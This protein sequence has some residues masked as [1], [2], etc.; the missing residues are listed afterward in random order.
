[1]G[2]CTQMRDA[3]RG[4][5]DGAGSCRSLRK[6]QLRKESYGQVNNVNL[7]CEVL[8]H[9]RCLKELVLSRFIQRDEDWSKLCNVVCSTHSLESLSIEGVDLGASCC[10]PGNGFGKNLRD[11]VT[12]SRFAKTRVRARGYMSSVADIEEIF[13][14]NKSLRDLDL[15]LFRMN[16]AQAR[17]VFSGLQANTFLEGMTLRGLSLEAPTKDSLLGC[18]RNGSIKRLSIFGDLDILTANQ[19]S[20]LI[21]ANQTKLEDFR[22]RESELND[23]FFLNLRGSMQLKRLE[24]YGKLPTEGSSGCGCLKLVS[25]HLPHLE[26]VESLLCANLEVRCIESSVAEIA[27]AMEQNW[28]LR[29]FRIEKR[30]FGDVLSDD[31]V[32]KLCEID[33]RTVRNRIYQLVRNGEL[34]N[35]SRL[36]PFLFESVTHNH[37][38]IFLGLQK[39]VDVVPFGSVSI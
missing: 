22:F 28:T 38:N 7:V 19:I 15:I 37:S 3:L 6:L 17:A 13:A 20:S 8:R 26:S 18:L 16:E 21:G 14:A 9:C 39:V 10:R 27:A 34:A 31:A 32:K 2:E 11:L 5:V 4:L 12:T 25:K 24:I 23:Q 36:A 30:Y 33:R 35:V 29:R 1:M